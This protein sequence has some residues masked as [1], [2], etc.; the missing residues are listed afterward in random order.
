MIGAYVKSLLDTTKVLN[1]NNLTWALSNDYVSNVADAREVTLSGNL[2]NNIFD[3]RPLGGVVTYDKLLWI[4]S[5]ITWKPEDV[6]KLYY[7]DKDVVSGAY[8]LGN[9]TVAAYPVMFGPPLTQEYVSG[10]KEEIEIDGAGFGFLCFR[11]GIFENL[12]RPWFKMVSKPHIVDGIEV[13]LPIMGEDLSLCQ[14]V[15]EIGFK[16]WLDPSVKVDHHKT[17]KLTW[18]GV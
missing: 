13:D 10:L 12:S 15:K 9:G 11:A 5:D 1:Q 18:N 6:L 14:R 8:I 17:I 7:S 3:S 2:T 4:D 16:I